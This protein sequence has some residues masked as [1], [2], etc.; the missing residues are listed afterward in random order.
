MVENE[1]FVEVTPC[2]KRTTPSSGLNHPGF[3]PPLDGGA[4]LWPVCRR[5]LG[6]S[7]WHCCIEA[8]RDN[9]RRKIFARAPPAAADRAHRGALVAKRVDLGPKAPVA[10]EDLSFE[11]GNAQCNSALLRLWNWCQGGRPGRRTHRADSARGVRLSDLVLGGLPAPVR[12][13][14]D[15]YNYLTRQVQ[16]ESPT[17]RRA[18]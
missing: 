13:A 12:D 3:C 2:N 6:G 8:S 16:D 11:P 5:A 1:S 15:G 7:K 18:S 9:R 14:G 4:G 10:Q 17:E